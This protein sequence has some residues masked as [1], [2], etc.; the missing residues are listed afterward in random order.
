MNNMQIAAVI[1]VIAAITAF[2]RFIPFMLFKNNKTPR[3]IAYLGKVL[4]YAVMGMLV[5]FCMK[6]MQVS[7]LSSVIPYLASAAVVAASYIFKRSTL[8]S[9]VGGTVFYMILVQYVFK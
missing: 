4:P 5:V 7:E 6:D 9:I 2:L 1:I 8:V 3:V